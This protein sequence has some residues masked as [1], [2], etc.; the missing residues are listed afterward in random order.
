MKDY[1]YSYLNS[2]E[3]YTSVTGISGI[4][5]KDFS[6]DNHALAL[7]AKVIEGISWLEQAMGKVL[8]NEYT[9]PLATADTKRDRNFTS[10]RDYI[11]SFSG[12]EDPAISGACEKLLAVIEKQGMLLHRFGYVKESTALHAIF[13]EFDQPAA[14]GYLT[15]LD[16]TSRSML[17]S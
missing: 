13:N 2:S 7:N 9:S 12:D 15:T 1:P 11:K 5:L 10:L 8:S 17:L 3:L 6:T 16:A 14:S 4:V